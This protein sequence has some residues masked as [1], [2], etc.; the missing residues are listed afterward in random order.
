MK[1]VYGGKEKGRQDD[2]SKKNYDVS[3]SCRGTAKVESTDDGQASQY[4]GDFYKYRHA[5]GLIYDDLRIASTERSN[6]VV[7]W[8]R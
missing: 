6:E 3:W 4:G 8:D 5:L 2:Q 1:L 7:P